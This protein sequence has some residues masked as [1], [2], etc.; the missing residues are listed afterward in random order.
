MGMLMDEHLVDIIVRRSLLMASQ[1][2]LRCYKMDSLDKPMDER[3]LDIRLVHWRAF[4]VQM[5]L[6]VQFRATMS[7]HSLGNL[8]WA[9]QKIGDYILTVLLKNKSSEHLWFILTTWHLP[10]HNAGLM[11]AG[12]CSALNGI[13]IA[14]ATRAKKKICNKKRL[15]SPI[16]F[17]CHQIEND[18]FCTIFW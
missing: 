2:E 4:L 18:N 17:H 12:Y 3:Q 9:E 15:M 7:C 1:F 6:L 8:L 10:G 13:D 5:T 11:F 14:V 16:T